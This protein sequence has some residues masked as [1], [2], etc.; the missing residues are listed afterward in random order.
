MKI[1]SQPANLSAQFVGNA[2]H[3]AGASPWG[4]R[5]QIVLLFPKK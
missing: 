2:V 4:M 1:G 3:P 5:L